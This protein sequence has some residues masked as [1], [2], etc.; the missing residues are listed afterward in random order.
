M[1]FWFTVCTA[2]L[3]F[4]ALPYLRLIIKR[5][6]FAV[7]VKRA[8]RQYHYT[9]QAAHPMWIF[10][11]NNSGHADFYCESQDD[12]RV[13]AVKL[14]GAVHR[15]MTLYFIDGDRYRWKREIPLFGKGVAMGAGTLLGSIVHEQ[16]TGIREWKPVDFAYRREDDRYK[17]IIPVILGN[18]V[19]L[20]VMRSK[21]TYKKDLYF[22]RPDMFAKEA[23]TV[24]QHTEIY[25]SDLIWDAYLFSAR[26]FIRE[27]EVSML[28]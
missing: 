14:V 13:Y 4:G 2:A 8:C 7:R 22:E 16:Y 24:F 11:L 19:P 23:E 21:E 15:M 1:E 28:K 6:S 18:P 27:L 12:N 5:I 26:G 10:A 17:R 20:H 3:I 9:F 25:D